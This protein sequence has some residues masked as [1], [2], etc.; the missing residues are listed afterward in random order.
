MF[1]IPVLIIV[2]V[3]LMS[4]GEKSD[5][6]VL[7]IKNNGEFI[8]SEKVENI[9]QYFRSLEGSKDFS[10]VILSDQD[11]PLER[12]SFV[13]ELAAQKTFKDITLTMVK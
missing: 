4:C 12:M 8:N 6:I 13:S 5:T 2:L 1:K 9:D 11:V 3:L 7:E 10:L